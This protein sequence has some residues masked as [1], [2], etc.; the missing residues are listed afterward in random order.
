[1]DGVGIRPALFDMAARLAAAGYTVLLPNLYYRAGRAEPFDP[2][3]V[4]AEGPERDRLTAMLQAVTPAAAMRDT[5]A[6]LAFL[7]A[8]PEVE[9]GK[10]GCVGYCMGGGLALT[11][12]GTFPDRFAAAASFHGG[13]LATDAPDSPHLL[14]PKIQSE[15]YIG[16]AG[17]DPWLAP[18]ETERLKAALEFHK[19]DAT[20][21]I[22][23]AVKHGFAP[24]D[25]PV[26]DHDASERHWERLLDLF[27]RAL[28]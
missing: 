25:M 8:R 13:R 1:M 18:G 20:V 10:I 2:A 7:D 4:F 21:E 12:A 28:G 27:G 16:V 3:T 24:P 22:Y 15:V 14:A 9:K 5:G 11:A 17:V 19:V 6:F 23:P 26:Y